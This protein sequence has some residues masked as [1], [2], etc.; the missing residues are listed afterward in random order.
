MD[1]LSLIG[2]I[3]SIAGI[4]ISGI[5]FFYAK[6]IKEH[7]NALKNRVIYN[8]RLGEYLDILQKVNYSFSESINCSDRYNIKLFLENIESTLLMLQ[9]IVPKEQQEM[10]KNCCCL[11]SKQYNGSLVLTEDELKSKRWWSLWH[12]YVELEDLQTT[13]IEVSS[14]IDKLKNL[15]IDKDITS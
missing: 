15:K 5:T 14:L 2:N 1:T 9:K 6:S 12:V 4:L 8:T 11:V 13:Y 10:C 7:V 3:C